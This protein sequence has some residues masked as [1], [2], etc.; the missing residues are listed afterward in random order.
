MAALPCSALNQR[1]YPLKEIA[2]DAESVVVGRVAS[3][4]PGAM[5]FVVIADEYL[6]GHQGFTWMATDVKSGGWG[7]PPILMRRVAPGLPAI[8]FVNQA[9]GRYMAVGYT[10]GTWFK[11]TAAPEKELD[12]MRWSFTNLE[13][14]L[15]RSFAGTTEELETL[16]RAHL[17]EGKELPAPSNFVNGSYGPE[18]AANY[19]PTS[20]LPQL[21]SFLASSAG[22]EAYPVLEVEGLQILSR[23]MSQAQSTWVMARYIGGTYLFSSSCG[24]VQCGGQSG[25][26]VELSLPVATDGTYDLAISASGLRTLSALV[27]TIDGAELKAQTPWPVPAAEGPNTYR[28]DPTTVRFGPVTLTKGGH[29]LRLAPE[30]ES[31]SYQ[32]SLDALVLLPPG[33]I[34]LS[35]ADEKALTAAGASAKDLPMALELAQAYWKSGQ[36]LAALLK[37]AKG[38]WT[39]VRWTLSLERAM[40]RGGSRGMRREASEILRTKLSDP[41]LTWSDLRGGLMRAGEMFLPTRDSAREI[42]RLRKLSN[43]DEADPVLM[44]A[45]FGSLSLDEWEAERKAS[46]RPAALGPGETPRAPL[47]ASGT[48]RSLSAGWKPCSTSAVA[49]KPSRAST[50]ATLKTAAASGTVMACAAPKALLQ[51]G[52]WLT[53]AAGPVNQGGFG[54]FGGGGRDGRGMGGP[55]M[56][57]PGGGGPGMGGPGGGG[58]GMGGPGGGPGGPFGGG[59]ATPAASPLSYWS[60]GAVT[61]DLR[62]AASYLIEARVLVPDHMDEVG[63][64]RN[65]FIYIQRPSRYL[66]AGVQF[67]DSQGKAVGGPAQVLKVEPL[68]GSPDTVRLRV[69][70]YTGASGSAGAFVLVTA[71]RGDS[72]ECG[73]SQVYLPTQSVKNDKLSL[74]AAF[75]LGAVSDGYVPEAHLGSVKISPVSYASRTGHSAAR[76][77]RP[78][79]GRTAK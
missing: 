6:K 10:N 26:D 45:K 57:G 3:V 9:Q 38:N 29:K 67:T 68:V 35:A 14:M 77:A 1:V 71:Y 60:K 7:H 27:V 36:E 42:L 70:V 62:Q 72:L 4:D 79:Q 50:G 43:W 31:G 8:L 15:R 2:A 20:P 37:Q 65:G 40:G 54:P 25:Q 18:V 44:A 75:G 61:I 74:C 47:A 34:T 5:R 49:V 52:A 78:I 59:A 32:I 53:A 39:D 28:G 56:G 17:K 46:L 51:T 55:G 58:P 13:V 66:G 16:L 22:S 30:T 48:A 19:A 11:V 12:R 24:V 23:T 69:D 73:R 41:W 64:T 76:A 63:E 21:P 33:G